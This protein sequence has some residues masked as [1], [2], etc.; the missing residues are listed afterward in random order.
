MSGLEPEQQYRARGGSTPVLHGR[1]ARLVVLDAEQIARPDAV[2]RVDGVET[3][4]IDA[5]AAF[6]IRQRRPRTTTALE[7][8]QAFAEQLFERPVAVGAQRLGGD[9]PAGRGV[10]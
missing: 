6:S 3:V 5:H 4:H 8:Q 10:K 7:A 2:E 1:T 9:E